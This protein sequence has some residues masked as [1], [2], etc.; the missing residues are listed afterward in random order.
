MPTVK[1]FIQNVV[2]DNETT[3]WSGYLSKKL[4]NKIE[5]RD[6]GV[7]VETTLQLEPDNNVY[8]LHF[9]FGEAG[10]LLV[11]SMII[12]REEKY[13]DDLKKAINTLINKIVTGTMTVADLEISQ[14]PLPPE[15]S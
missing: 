12:S 3:Y 5:G 1:E 15:R 9:R 13:K 2:L 11:A 10:V 8:T 4:L 14:A 7:R 6:V